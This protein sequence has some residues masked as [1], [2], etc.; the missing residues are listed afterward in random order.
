MIIYRIYHRETGKSYIGQSVTSFRRRYSGGRWWEQTTNPLLF[1]A[2]QKYGHHAFDVEILEKDITDIAQLNKLE[3]FYAQRFNAYI[4]NG[5]NLK[6]CGD[7]RLLSPESIEKIRANHSRPFRVRRIDTWEIVEGVNLAAFCRTHGLSNSQMKY[8]VK[9]PEKYRTHKGFCSVSLT[10]EQLDNPKLGERVGKRYYLQHKDGRTL[11]VSNIR[12]TIQEYGFTLASFL[13][14]LDKKQLEYQGWRLQERLDEVSKCERH[15]TLRAPT[16]EIIS[17]IGIGNFCKKNNL[18]PQAIGAVLAKRQLSHRGWKLPETTDETIISRRCLKILS[19]D[20][21]DPTGQTIH[22][23]NLRLFCHQNNLP[24]E[25][26]YWL[27][28]EKTSE[29]LGWKRIGGP[30]KHK[31]KGW[32]QIKA[33]T[34][35]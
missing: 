9:H 26:F 29:V 14:L 17:G 3:H 28:K 6:N 35:T 21:I 18:R 4:P 25:P 11:V 12:Q 16:G 23:D 30:P 10:R 32:K 31:C 34:P 20:L 2:A 22:I 19:L 33:Q 5:F 27:A 15:F 1:N 24:Y 7:N 13:R 8:I